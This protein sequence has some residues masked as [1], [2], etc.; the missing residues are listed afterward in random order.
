[1]NA[2]TAIS[3]SKDIEAAWKVAI[4]GK[5]VHGNRSDCSTGVDLAHQHNL[6]RVH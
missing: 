3:R 5:L 1:M 4:M 2:N 6:N